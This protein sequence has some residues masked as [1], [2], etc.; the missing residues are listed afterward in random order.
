MQLKLIN[1]HELS[2]IIQ[3]NKTY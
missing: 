2:L 3:L 1:L